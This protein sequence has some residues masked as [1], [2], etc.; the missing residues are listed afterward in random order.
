MGMFSDLHK[1]DLADQAKPEAHTSK[2]KA[3]QQPQDAARPRPLASVTE[4][5]NITEREQEERREKGKEEK[6]EGGKEDALLRNSDD[7]VLYDLAVKPY[8][9][10]SFNFTTEEFVELGKLKFEL[11]GTYDLEVG[12]DDIARCAFKLMLADYRTHGEQSA[13]V[14][15]LKRKRGK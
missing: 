5:K 12:K 7:I 15:A 9:K 11:I 1:Q 2:S 14:Q 4:P 10:D 3:R 6:K 13:L 8:R